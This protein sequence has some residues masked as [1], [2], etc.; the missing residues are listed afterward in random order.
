MSARSYLSIGDVLTL[1]RQEFPDVTISKIR[2]LE[3]QGLVD[4]E[5]TPSGYRKFYEHDVERLRW[6]LRQQREHFLPLKVIKDRL[7]DDA[8]G[9]GAADRPT[10]AATAVAV[11]R[12]VHRAWRRADADDGAD[13]V[14]GTAPASDRC[15]SADTWPPSRARV[16]TDP[17]RAS[18]PVL[19]AAPRRLPGI[20]SAPTSRAPPPSEPKRRTGPQH[21]DGQRTAWPARASS[22]SPAAADMRRPAEPPA[23][24]RPAGRR[25]RTAAIGRTA[26]ASARPAAAT[27]PA[28]RRAAGRRRRPRPRAERR[29]RTVPGS[30]GAGPPGSDRKA[31]SSLRSRS[32]AAAC[33]LDA[34]VV[35]EL[36]EFGLLT[37]TTWPASSAS[38]R[39]PWP[40]PSWR[41][42]SPGSA[43][44]PATCAS[45]RTPP[46][47]KRDSSS[48]SCCRWSA[49]AIPRPGPG[50]TRPPTS[51]PLLGQQLRA[52]LLR[53]ALRDLLDGYRARP[54]R[55]S[56]RDGIPALPRL[57]APIG[58]GE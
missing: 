32:C 46:T 57:I 27:A 30:G 55:R 42:S 56:I 35:A 48:R 11:R 37:A 54:D 1:L 26:A 7:D 52:S 6:V 28:C 40:W 33:G 12:P 41:P 10:L 21:V 16:A 5:R 53:S 22:A 8:G 3:S 38:T 39:R 9:V 50:P 44:S 58:H 34:A 45:T 15:W 17:R 18:R 23:S 20:E 14:P 4:P 31:A 49:S 36:Q 29:H 2:F 43:S 25:R 19:G 13:A 24:G 47:A 51:W